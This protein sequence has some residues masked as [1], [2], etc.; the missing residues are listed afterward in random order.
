MPVVQAYCYTKYLGVLEV[1]FDANGELSKPVQG[2]GVSKAEVILLDNSYKMDPTVDSMMDRYREDLEPYY[3]VIGDTLVDLV[4]PPGAVESNLGD[5]LADS[6]VWGWEGIGPADFGVINN[7][8]IR[9]NIITGEITGEDVYYVIP[10]EN[11][12][13]KCEILGFD[14]KN[15]LEDYATGLNAT[16]PSSSDRT[17]LQ[18][19]KQLKV[20]YNVRSDNEMNRVETLEVWDAN[21]GGF[22]PMD[23]GKTYNLVLG[24]WLAGGGSRTYDFPSFCRNIQKGPVDYDVFSAYVPTISPINQGVEGRITFKYPE[25]EGYGGSGS[26]IRAACFTLVSTLIFSTL[27]SL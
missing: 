12:L 15:Q 9:S 21:Q 1:N 2:V 17:F 5:L 3:T 19:S 7:G 6:Y 13:D 24:S 14:F 11:T 18:I 16:N 10:F 20:V 4:T 23:M 26:A 27:L 25:V 22:V 8:G